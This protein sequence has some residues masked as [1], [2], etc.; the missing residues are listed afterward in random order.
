MKKIFLAL[1]L[2]C[3]IQPT[4]A[5]TTASVARP[6]L[7]VGIV[8]DQMRWDYLIRYY[9]HYCDG[10]FKRLL[11]EGFSCD[12]NQLN[13]IPTVTAI[14]HSSIYTGSVPSIHGIAGNNF[15]KDGKPT[16]CTDDA[17]VSGVGSDSE[18]GKMS[19]RNLLVTT[20]GDELRMA[21]NFRS[22][23]VGVSLKDRASILPAGHAANGAYWFDDAT[24]R[25]I[26]STYYMTEL[27][28]WVKRFNSQDLGRQYLSK[29]WETLLPAAEYV[30]S[31]ADDTPYEKAQ[32]KGGRPTLPLD[33]PAL[34]KSQGYK[35]I[36][37]SPFGNSL[38]LEIAKAA[39]EGEN[40]G[41]GTE[42]DLLAVSLSSTDYVGHQFGVNAIETEDTYLRLDRDLADFLTTLDNAVGKGNYLVFL[43]ADHAGAHNWG[44]LNDH[45]IPAGGWDAAVVKDSLNKQ[46]AK[47]FNTPETLVKDVLNYQVYID[48]DAIAKAGLELKSV[49]QAVIDL[50]KADKTYAYVTDM[51][52]LSDASIPEPIRSRAING[53]NRFRSGDI[54]AV[55]QPGYYEGGVG[56]TNHGV[57]NPYDAHIPLLFMG[58]GVKHGRTMLPTAMTDIAPTVCALLNIQMP[59]GCVGN[60]IL[61]VLGEN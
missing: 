12:N 13:Y 29:K 57:W 38:T 54:L 56:G 4:E 23:V 48:R 33:L 28:E 20:I 32:V 17:T 40:L 7:V 30:Q 47:A 52:C 53:Y 45:G 2:L 26:S 34:F 11:N 8:V 14:G 61:P 21:T 37:V 35:A 18:A 58:W 25:F 3:G 59:N 27:P 22:K 51:E 50:L 1:L 55:M 42:T 43:T 16:Y 9:D 36:R 46:L 41:R 44:F 10:G 60:A 24:G 19:P 5:Q 6:R 15:Y 49:K 39:L 31:T